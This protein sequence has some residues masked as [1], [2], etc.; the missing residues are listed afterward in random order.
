MTKCIACNQENAPG[1]AFCEFCGA[2]LIGPAPPSGEDTVPHPAHRVVPNTGP[3]I[4][5]KHLSGVRASAEDVF[6]LHEHDMLTL[7][8]DPYSHIAFD[9]E[10]DD[11]VSRRHAA[12]AV[13]RRRDDTFELIDLGSTNGVFVNG[14]RLSGKGK[15]KHGDVIRVGMEGP[16]IRF[17]LDPPP[18]ADM[19]ETRIVSAQERALLLDA[20]RQPHVP[21]NRTDE[22]VIAQKPSTPLS[23]RDENAA[24]P[25]RPLESAVQ[26]DAARLWWQRV[27]NPA[28]LIIA[29]LVVMAIVALVMLWRDQSPARP[30]PTAYAGPEE[31]A[32]AYRR[33]DYAT[34]F[35][36]FKALAE[37][38]D[39]DAAT[40]VGA[41]YAEGRGT[42]RDYG[43]ALQWS[44][45][46]ADRGNARA[47]YNVGFMYENGMGVPENF[48]QA[49]SWYEKAA[50]KGEIDAISSL[51]LLYIAGQGVRTDVGKGLSLMQR[52]ADQGDAKAQSKLGVMLIN[53]TDVPVDKAAGFGWLQ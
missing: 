41:L 33:G 27:K 32:K 36:E 9:S 30:P 19:D 43:Q 3:V 18:P 12:I 2:K 29:A 45:K 49:A 53:G 5:I 26:G 52:A 50:A 44:T 10:R 47:Q 24:K 6:G 23:R 16:E 11:S 37:K 17:L 51:G 38:G 14:Q 28:V 40:M 20:L 46:A 42:P 21:Q 13:D 35:K 22:T 7:G 1:R 4:R 25:V 48:A 31:A 15:I 8:R 39:P 34:A